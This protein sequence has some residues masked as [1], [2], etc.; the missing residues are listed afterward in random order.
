MVP[1]WFEIQRAFQHLN[2]DCFHSHFEIGQKKS[3]LGFPKFCFLSEC[4]GK[5]ILIA[6]TILFQNP[7]QIEPQHLSLSDSGSDCEIDLFPTSTVNVASGVETILELSVSVL[8]FIIIGSC[9]YNIIHKKGW[10]F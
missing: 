8:L 2:P 7:T 10:T 1:Q 5:Q 3:E 6:D 4:F 9:N